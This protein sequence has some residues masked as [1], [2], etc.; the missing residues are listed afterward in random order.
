ME[1]SDAIE[2]YFQFL[3]VEKGD[4]KKT[5][6][7][8]RE[9]IKMF[10]NAFPNIKAT[11]DLSEHDLNDFAVYEGKKGIS[12]RSIARRISSI[13][14]FYAFLKKSKDIDIELDN[15]ITP[16]M[17]KKLPTCLSYEEIKKLLEAPDITNPYGLRD[18]SMLE[19]MY[20]SSLRVSE[21]L[22]LKREQVDFI[23]GI[24]T[25]IGKGNKERKVPISEY[26]LKILKEYID[27]P[28]KKN[29]GAASKYIFL[30]SNGKPLSRQYF[31][32]QIKKYAKLAGI[33]KEISPHTIRHC[34]ATHMLENG[35]DLITV[36]KILGHVNLATTQIYTH[37]TS[38]RMRNAYDLYTKR[39]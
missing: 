30:N 17:I 39:K 6:D 18:R 38:E 1:I 28:R 7:A 5:I 16:K 14:N 12:S 4:S 29:K 35:A 37:V 34:S 10:L 21:L 36:Q 11:S 2:K 9:D 8:Y 19:V 13:K 25:V 23:N 27:G 33:K 26:S 22:S 20:S 3:L 31:F 32:L 15:V 24:V